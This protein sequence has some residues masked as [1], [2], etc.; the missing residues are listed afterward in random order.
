[1]SQCT[2]VQKVTAKVISSYYET[3]VRVNSKN[4][5]LCKLQL[6]SVRGKNFFSVV[7]MQFI[8]ES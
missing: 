2:V 6:V 8:I 4:T 7:T 3:I 1:M 5:V